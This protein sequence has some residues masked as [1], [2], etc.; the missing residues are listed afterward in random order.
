[1]MQRNRSR[2]AALLL[3]AALAACSDAPTGATITA[4][5][6][7]AAPRFNAAPT[8]TVTNSGGYPLISWGALAGAT[9]YSV[10]NKTRYVTVMN[11]KAYGSTS[12]R[13]V[14]STTGTSLVDSVFSY[15]GVSSC[16][17]YFTGEPSY[18]E[19]Q[20]QSYVVTATFAS[21]T[22][23]TTVDAPIAEC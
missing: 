16:T 10:V 19:N 13:L 17:F 23:T 3:M 14:G 5:E 11:G 1:M 22:S 9:S 18:T 15:T 4:A 8:V 20:S 21:G 12:N 2:A 7:V 6:P